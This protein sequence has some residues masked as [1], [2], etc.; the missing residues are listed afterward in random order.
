MGCTL[1]RHYGAALEDAH[2]GPVDPDVDAI[3]RALY[4][5][6]QE[7]WRAI[8]RRLPSQRDEVHA[9]IGA[10]VCARLE[11]DYGGRWQ[12]TVRRTG[13]PVCFG[14]AGVLSGCM[15]KSRS[16]VSIRLS[17]AQS[18][19]AKIHFRLVAAI[20]DTDAGERYDYEVRLKM[21]RSDNPELG[22]A[23]IA[24][25]KGHPARSPRGSPAPTDQ[26]PSR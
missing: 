9:Q 7:A 14:R 2:H 1:A 20:S 25:I 26:L 12:F 19:G 24:A 5:E 4:Q 23:V 22:E 8:R 15:R 18:T 13:S 21:D 3:C 17:G 16:S 11:A 6:H 10:R